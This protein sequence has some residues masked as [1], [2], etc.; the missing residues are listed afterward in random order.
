MIPFTKV[1]LITKTYE[2]KDVIFFDGT[3]EIV[4]VQYGI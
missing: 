2:N 4:E 1:N 3:K